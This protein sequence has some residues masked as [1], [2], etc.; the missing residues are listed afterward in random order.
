MPH[1]PDGSVGLEP[2]SPEC[3][4][5]TGVL[6]RDH[7][8]LTV[9]CCWVLQRC[10]CQNRAP[11]GEEPGGGGEQEKLSVGGGRWGGSWQGKGAQRG[12]FRRPGEGLYG[13]SVMWDSRAQ[14]N[15]SRA[16]LGDHTS[17]QGSQA[18]PA[19]PVYLLLERAQQAMQPDHKR[20]PL[21]CS[22]EQI[23]LPQRKSKSSQVHEHR[24]C[25]LEAGRLKCSQEA[26]SEA[27]NGW[28]MHNGG[29]RCKELG[30]DRSSAYGDFLLNKYCR[31]SA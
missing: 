28:Q 24:I 30:T 15:S 2:H 31:I 8:L 21:R 29:A 1:L 7:C 10:C 26:S 17:M 25:C 18:A 9:L 22:P 4:I 3:C 27:R 16:L 12:A 20:S 19:E 14:P 13:G 11:E 5:Y 6:T 23:A